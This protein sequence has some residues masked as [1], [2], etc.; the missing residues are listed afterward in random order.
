[1]TK[2]GTPYGSYNRYDILRP[3]EFRNVLDWVQHKIVALAE[4][5]VSGRIEAKPYRYR[6][7]T[8]CTYCDYRP[9]CRFDWQ[10]NDYRY[11][12]PKTKSDV[13]ME[14]SKK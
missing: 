13:V 4:D 5:R 1:M 9:V 11:L 6:D 3:D 2:D 7:E 8:P 14:A 12:D 10:I